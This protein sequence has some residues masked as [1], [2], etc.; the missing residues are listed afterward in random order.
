MNKRPLSISVIGC[1]FLAAGLI[2]IARYATEFNPQ[3][4]LEYDLVLGCLVQLLAILGGVFVLRANNWARW[5]LLAWLAFHVIL[6]AFHS[7][8]ELIVHS[9]LFAVVAYILFRPPASA[10][11]WGARAEPPQTP[12]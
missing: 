2:G 10:Y 1:I 7:L 3:R 5:F 4:L 12:R 9:L 11:F 8:F 6:S